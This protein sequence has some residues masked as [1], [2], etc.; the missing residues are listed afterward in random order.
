MYAV[1]YTTR[2]LPQLHFGLMIGY[3]TAPFRTARPLYA[4]DYLTLIALNADLDGEAGKQQAQLCYEAMRELVLET[5]E[6][7]ALLGDVSGDGKVVTGAIQQRA[8]LLKLED[9][10][11]FLRVVTMQAAGMAEEAGRV[12]DAVLLF[13]LAEQYDAVLSIC[14]RAVSESIS[15]EL[16]Q[17]PMR[18]EPLKPAPQQQQ[19]GTLSKK[20]Q[21]ASLSLTSVE[22]PE[23]LARAMAHLYEQDAM[24][25][26]Q[27]KEQ[28]REACQAL[29]KISHAKR[30]IEQGRWSEGLEI[31]MTT[32]I[33][34][35]SLNPNAFPIP[36]AQPTSTALSRVT[37]P[38]AFSTST[39]NLSLIRDRASLLQTLPSALAHTVPALLLMT[40]TALSRWREEIQSSP[41]SEGDATRRGM[42]KALGDAAK[43]L[44]VYAGLVRYK[45]PGRVFERL[46]E[47]IGEDGGV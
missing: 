18:L 36:S 33:L 6:F 23:Q 29:V 27:I 47:V 44:M 17:G 31:I 30:T 41:F 32:K 3:Y 13:H 45:L 16:G 46:G 34:P 21:S 14:N 22:D 40:L 20:D 24:V 7:A 37:S 28:N 12:T 11:Q 19:N 26:R 4:V 15:L 35:L 39:Q 1:T 25:F 10:E 2:Q 38:P 9:E 43:D 42:V 5:R 8:A